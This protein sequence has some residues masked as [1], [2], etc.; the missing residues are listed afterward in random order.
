MFFLIGERLRADG[1]DNLDKAT[2]DLESANNN[3]IDDD[4]DD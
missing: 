3:A 4:D 1:I 2:E